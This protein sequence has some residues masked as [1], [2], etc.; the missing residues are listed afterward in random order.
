MSL[1]QRFI[2]WWS[3]RLHI[4]DVPLS[5][6]PDYMYS[7]NYWLG[8][9]VAAAFFYEIITGLFLLLY[10]APSEPYTQTMYLIQKVPYGSLLLATHLYGAYAM[11]FLAYVHMF[12]NYFVKA[13]KKPRE[14]Q[15]MVGVILLTLLQGVA[16]MGYSMTGDILATDAVDVGRGIT[17]GFP[18]V[19]KL[20]ESII[21]GNGTTLDLF[22]R[23]LGYHVLL[24]ALTG[25]LFGYHFYLAEMN[26][27]MPHPKKAA[28]KAPAI[29]DQ[30]DTTLNPWYPRN[31]LY[32]LELAFFT[33]GFIIIIP[34]ILSILPHVPILFS[35][36]PSVSPTSP[37][38]KTIPAYPP[39]FFLFMYKVLDFRPLSPFDVVI[40]SAF[41]P[42]L[43]F[44]FV[45]ILDRSDS[46]HPLSGWV[47]QAIGVIAIINFIQASVW[48]AVAPGVP[49]EPNVYI[50]VL[51]EPAIIVLIGFY[52][53]AK[54][55]GPH[56]QP[57]TNVKGAAMLITLLATAI[58]LFTVTSNSISSLVE[59]FSATKV[60]PV[61]SGLLST[62]LIGVVL[63]KIEV[64]STEKPHVKSMKKKIG[65]GWVYFFLTFL[66]VL[67]VIIAVTIWSF[68]PITQ[69]SY[70]GIGL[71]TLFVI[72][73][74]VIALYHYA[75][76]SYAKKRGEQSG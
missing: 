75:V 36:Y 16:F 74:E 19:G 29:I 20:F 55:Y 59:S 73:G 68:D 18:L 24:V 21:F 1:R 13:Y 61:I 46:L 53:L 34:S 12:R 6:I 26:G 67:A 63:M 8:S 52:F 15:W 17:E 54:R 5:K 65:L 10:Y 35:P 14:L 27:F 2:N 11:I 50:P 70:F 56:A 49:V 48:A 47:F 23:L 45:P 33:F 4:K 66:V 42:I 62:G 39:W 71:G 69:A 76:Y 43:Y 72:F 28:Y 58:G 41:V 32:M 40:I 3:D 7:V 30:K 25:L 60:V 44:L 64:T 37:Q 31:L 51:A 38:A 9:M 57:S 22:T